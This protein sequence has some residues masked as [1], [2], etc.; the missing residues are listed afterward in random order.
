MHTHNARRHWRTK[1]LPVSHDSS[2]MLPFVFA[3]DPHRTV[4]LCTEFASIMRNDSGRGGIFGGRRLASSSNAATR[5]SRADPDTNTR[6]QGWMFELDGAS[7]AR[8]TAS[9]T[10]SRGTGR[11]K[12]MR[13]E[14]R[15]RIASSRSSIIFLGSLQQRGTSQL[16][17]ASRADN[18]TQ[19]RPVFANLGIPPGSRATRS[20]ARPDGLARTG[21][22]RTALA[23]YPCLLPPD[24][25][26][27]LKKCPE[28]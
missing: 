13:V 24:S 12:N 16:S 1:K 8:A 28:P 17:N 4:D 3:A 6:C 25:N 21:A 5:R 7:C 20:L 2:V 23:R 19:S 26:R 18:V 9:L 11:G 27:G 15:A 14:W 22:N 10:N